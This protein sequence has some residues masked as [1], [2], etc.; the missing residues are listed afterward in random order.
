LV[1]EIQAEKYISFHIE[2]SLIASF[3]RAMSF[4][5]DDRYASMSVATLG[6]S[7]IAEGPKTKYV[8][9]PSQIF[10]NEEKG[11]P[12][13]FFNKPSFFGT[14][15]IEGAQPK[16]AHQRRVPGD[17]LRVSDIDGASV[18]IKDKFLHTKRHEDPLQP[19][20]KLPSCK[21]VPPHELKFVKDSMSVDDIDGTRSTVKTVYQARDTLRI[22]DIEGSSAGWKPRHQ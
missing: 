19:N 8:H 5:E 3:E 21:V 9:A 2:T 6:S 7:T 17:N 12:K 14:S 4:P 10:N 1:E 20:Y 18:L 11:G 13:T 22:S 16:R 15:D